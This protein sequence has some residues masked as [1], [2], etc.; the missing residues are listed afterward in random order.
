M[1]NIKST[2][3]LVAKSAFKHRINEMRLRM[4]QRVVDKHYQDLEYAV[5]CREYQHKQQSTDTDFFE[6]DSGLVDSEF[7]YNS[8]KQNSSLDDSLEMEMASIFNQRNETPTKA[9]LSR[10]STPIFNRSAASKK[11][12]NRVVSQSDRVRHRS[13]KKRRTSTMLSTPV[14][15]KTCDQ[16]S[17]RYTMNYID[18]NKN[19]DLNYNINSVMDLFYGAAAVTGNQS[20]DGFQDFGGLKVWYV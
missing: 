2:S 3:F 18:L 4:K 11:L 15:A 19:N 1:V 8:T 6:N 14:S 9:V 20:S 10:T 12:K 7:Q 16:E 17:C 5:K 13:S